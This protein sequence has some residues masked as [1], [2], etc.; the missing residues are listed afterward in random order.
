MPVLPANWTELKAFVHESLCQKENL[1]PDQFP[2][3]TDPLIQRDRLCG[4]TFTLFGPRQIRLNAVWATEM[5]TI[6][7]YDARGVRYDV[8][9]LPHRL[10]IPELPS[11][12]TTS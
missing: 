10:E 12:A 11:L 7:L 5:N 1:I 9:K 3:K 4:M 2:L 6:F 8:V